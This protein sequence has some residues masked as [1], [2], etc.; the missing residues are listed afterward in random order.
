MAAAGFRRSSSAREAQLVNEIG[1]RDVRLNL[2]M[3]RSPMSLQRSH[4]AAV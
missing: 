1:L 3:A 4:S 2:T